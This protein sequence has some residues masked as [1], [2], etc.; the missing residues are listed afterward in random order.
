MKYRKPAPG[1]GKI[2]KIISVIPLKK[3]VFKG[4][5]TY[6]TSLDISVGSIVTVPVRS[7]EIIA[8]VT[9]SLE[10]RDGKSSVKGMNFNLRKVIENKGDSIFLKEF[11]DAIFETSKYFAQNINNAFAS[12]IPNIFIEEYD[13]IKKIRNDTATDLTKS[14]LENENKLRAEK[15]LMQCGMEE[16]I[17]IYKTLVRESFARGKSIFIVLSTEIDIDEFTKQLSKGI[18]QYTFSMQSGINEKKILLN[19]ERIITSAHPVLIIGTPPFLS[20]PK[21]DIGTVI[22][23]HESANTYNMIRRPHFDLRVFVEIYASKINAKFI[24]A[25]RLLRLE[26]IGRVDRD[27]L[28]PLH[29]LSFRVDFEGKIVVLGKER[30]EGNKFQILDA[31]CME[32]MKVHLENKKSVFIFALR[33]GL[34]TTTVC[35]DCGETVNCERCG[36]PLVLYLS[37]QSKKRMFVCNRC[38]VE[39]N[40]ATVCKSCGSWNLVGLGIGTDTVQEEVKKLF[41]KNKIFRLDKESAKTALG[42]KKIIKEFEENP[43]SIL[44]GTEMAFFY[45]KNKVPLSIIAS[46]DSL[47][48]IPNFK[49]SE[50]I[51]QIVLSIIDKTTDKIIIQTKNEN[52]EAVLAIK[53][54]NLLPFVRGE[55]E[56]RKKLNYPPFKRFIKITHLGDKE[57]T[58][59]AKK[60]LE[61]IFNGYSPEVFSGFVARLKDKYTTNALIKIDPKK[62]SLPE[63]SIGSSIDEIL[64]TKLLTLA[65]SFE[66]FVDPEDLL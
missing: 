59:K 26:T 7:K 66:I 32:E 9:S 4:D 25:D 33:K 49:M 40:G 24:M 12:L 1:R 55:L 2:M 13:L 65:P 47:W 62:W 29:P 17:S 6:F 63:L 42:A 39:I 21:K 14:I 46:F 58:I 31:K 8:L 15:L 54:A 57:Q 41:P 38:G 20:I 44:I 64:L 50:R 16:R 27:N 48:S 11:L 3:G 22:L 30:K 18:E 10:L 53:S 45:L 51:I 37:H 43:G 52:D 36:A 34:A 56:D 23:E 5:L 35:K 61:E 28:N 60:V 19:Y